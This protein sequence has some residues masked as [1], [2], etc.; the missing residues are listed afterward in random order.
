MH[1]KRLSNADLGMADGGTTHIGL[2]RDM[3]SGWS[4]SDKTYDCYLFID[5]LDHCIECQGV[6]KAIE[7]QDGRIDAPR[8]KSAPTI[9]P[10]EKNLYRQILDHATDDRR[11]LTL[12]ELPDGKLLAFLGSEAADIDSVIQQVTAVPEEPV[13]NFEDMLHFFSKHV[14]LANI[15]VGKP[16]CCGII[17]SL[18]AKNFLILTGLSGSGKTKLAQA[19]TK[20]IGYDATSTAL[21]PVG[22]D[23][24]SREQMLGYHDG[25]DSERY[26]K[27]AS[28]ELIIEASKPGNE[29]KPYFIIL[30]EMNLSHVER[31]FSDF[32]SAIESE[33]AIP[34]HGE[35][36]TDD[37]L[38]DGVTKR[39]KLPKNL[40]VIGTVNVDETTYL[41]SPKVLDRANVIE[42]R[43]KSEDFDT[44]MKDPQAVDLDKLA[45]AEG[46]GFGHGYGAN[47]V[48][49]AKRPLTKTDLDSTEHTKLKQELGVLIRVFGAFGWEFGFRT[50]KEVTRFAYF[51]NLISAGGYS[52][53]D[54]LDAQIIQK[55]MPKLNGSEDKLRKILLAIAWYSS[56]YEAELH[57]GELSEAKIEERAKALIA[58][59]NSGNV[60]D[61]EKLETRLNDET[62][63]YNLTFDKALRMWR[64]V[65]AN[66]FTSFAEN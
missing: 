26:I 16:Q 49:E 66:G 17:S 8:I 37:H 61:P 63:K 27:Q 42:F 31:Y 40:F 51:H 6:I 45:D 60:D 3:L 7:R 10:N 44:F 22:A 13:V 46:K 47:F 12:G 54:A 53:E 41:F 34:M 18:L 28:L 15:N 25:I 20:W 24:T 50:G 19:F 38:V 21:V 4:N 48:S 56:G 52:F 23:W 9:I 5:D 29:D 39:L 11:Y 59:I 64:A 58:H 55:L 35:G 33:E 1:K 62:A 36:E 14:K 65:R 32:L 43:V 30:D 57:E 2:H